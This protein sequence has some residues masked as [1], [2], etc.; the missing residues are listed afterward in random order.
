MVALII[1]SYNLWKL[2]SIV[3]S[4]NTILIKKLRLLKVTIN[5]NYNAR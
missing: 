2:Q 4:I 3:A 1:R 5:E